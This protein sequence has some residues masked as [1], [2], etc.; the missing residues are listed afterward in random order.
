MDGLP[1]FTSEFRKEVQLVL[2]LPCR[3]RASPRELSVS[4]ARPPDSLPLTLRLQA[5]ADDLDLELPDDPEAPLHKVYRESGKVKLGSGA[6]HA[7]RSA[8]QA[9]KKR[10]LVDA[11]D[12]P[13]LTAYRDGR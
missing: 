10:K 12:L 11:G 1:K 9:Q 3:Y 13:I 4:F 5:M 7:A 2:S 8:P 6:P